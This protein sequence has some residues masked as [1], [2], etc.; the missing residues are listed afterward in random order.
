M[1]VIDDIRPLSD[2]ALT[3][4]ARLQCCSMTVEELLSLQEGSQIETERAAGDNIDVWVGGQS[5]ATGEI[6]VIGNSLGFRI[7]DFREKF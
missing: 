7:A 6:I 3:V 4:E 2:I 1:S 5:I